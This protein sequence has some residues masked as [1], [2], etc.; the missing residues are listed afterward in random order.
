VGSAK[1]ANFGW[2]CYEGTQPLSSFQ[3]LK[4]CQDLYAEQGAVVPPAV[5]Y[6]HGAF[7]FGGDNCGALDD[8]AAP[9]EG[10][11]SAVAFYQGGAYPDEYDGALFI[12]DYARGCMWVVR[13]GANGD[14]DP[15]T[16]QT[17]ASAVGPIV[18]LQTGPGG[19]LYYVDI[20]AGTLRRISYGSGG[21]TPPPPPPPSGDAPTPT[22]SAPTTSTTWAV[23]ETV[24]F[25]GSA[26]DA[27]GRALPASALSWSVILHHCY[28]ADQCHE[29]PYQT[30]DGVTEGSFQAPDHE[31]PAHLELRLDATDGAGRIG[32]AS[33]RIDPRTVELTFESQPTGLGIVL[34]GAQPAATPFTRTS[35]VGSGL[36][37]SVPSPQQ[38]GDASYQFG[39][40]SDGGEQS[41]T[42]V[43]PASA[44]TYGVVFQSSTGGAPERLAGGSREETAA[45]I[46]RAMFAPG[47]PVAYISRSDTF[48]DALAGGPA[49][50]R[51]G[52][53]ILL[54][55]GNAVPPATAA[56]LQR[57]RPQ[58]IVILGGTQ[59]VSGG[60]EASLVGY[61]HVERI[62]GD[63]RY[64][65]AAL[66]SA[67][68]F[69]GG[70]PV[71]Y[72]AT[73]EAFPDALAG[74]AAAGLEGGPVLLVGKGFVPEATAAELRRLQPG[75]IVVL[76]GEVA[77]SPDV[78]TTL[79]GLAPSVVRR[80]GA[81]R[82]A[83]ASA[84]SGGAFAAG[85]EKVYLA[86]GRRFADALAGVPAAGRDQAP[87][88][89]VDFD[90][91]PGSVAAELQ[92]LAPA[93]IVVLG[94]DTAVAPAVL[95]AVQAYQRR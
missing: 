94:G 67:Q 40:W 64:A 36:S 48:P 85:V 73:G 24:N 66:V 4:I 69:P 89:L 55:S 84:I 28:T 34:G 7:V 17:F 91:V 45:A 23:G 8:G 93:R 51:L 39:S 92:R 3:S 14:P 87:V 19:D 5:T 65:T 27:A 72:V 11:A 53:P 76:G 78:E 59:A 95:T 29:H 83:T 81:D 30:F 70:A 25:A 38:L 31:Y 58:R 13:A 68:T 12:G 88:L 9:D 21:G 79:R 6:Q 46:S 82:Y 16:I 86:T 26:K 10:A 74:G 37:V 44:A 90:S 41:H 18:D 49:G 35:I 77:I 47:A 75:R 22:M 15:S 52:G 33:T 20:Y 2:P 71:A 63:D 61:G 57:L 56:E 80:Q 1:P 54:V 60:V 42:I 43:T 62:A 32:T 50:A